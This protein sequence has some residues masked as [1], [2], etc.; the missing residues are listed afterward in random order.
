MFLDIALAIFSA[1]GVSHLFDSQ[2]SPLLVFLSLIFIFIP[3]IDVL[4]PSFSRRFLKRHVVNHRTFWHYPLVHVCIGIA[5]ATFSLPLGALYV[6]TT[7]LHFVHDTFF[8]GW[9]VVWFWPFKETRY[10]YF[11]D[12]YGKITSIP[13]VTWE[14]EEEVELVKKY[15]N[16][17][18]IRDFYLRPNI[19]AYIEYAALV[20]SLIFLLLAL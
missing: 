9:G 6:V 12:R 5:L 18:W 16:K 20:S 15:N 4:W 2:F 11:P 13:L 19:V 7:L 17:N 14:K 10:K 8:L 3:D 1:Y